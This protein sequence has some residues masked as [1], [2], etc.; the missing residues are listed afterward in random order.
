MIGKKVRRL[1]FSKDLAYY[2]QNKNPDHEI[3]KLDLVVGD[4]ISYNP[5]NC[6]FGIMGHKGFLLRCAV[7][8]EEAVYL[9]EGSNRSIVSCKVRDKELECEGSSIGRAPDT[10]K[11]VGS[12]PAPPDLV[13]DSSVGRASLLEVVCSSQTPRT[14]YQDSL[15][16]KP[17]WNTR[18]DGG[19]N[20]SPD[21]HASIAQ[22]V[23]HR[24]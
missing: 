19:E 1:T 6:L 13:A 24:Q 22:L 12:S 11:V 10:V 16:L 3:W 21:T 15:N 2:I 20:P 7:S 5:G 8:F 14:S 18:Y 23:E 9:T 17:R 4:V